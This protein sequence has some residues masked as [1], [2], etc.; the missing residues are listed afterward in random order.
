MADPTGA[1]AHLLTYHVVKGQL[2]PD[3]LAGEHTTLQGQSL[4]ITGSG[5]SFTVNGSAMVVCGN[6]HTDNAT[7]SIIDMVLHPPTG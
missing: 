7:V 3:K 2:A 1:L 6:I 4:M 5:E